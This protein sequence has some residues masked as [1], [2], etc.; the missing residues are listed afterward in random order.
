[1]P[2]AMKRK[3]RTAIVF[4]A[5]ATTG[6]FYRAPKNWTDGLKPIINGH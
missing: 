1:M 3:N 6:P 2:D 4:A 5:D